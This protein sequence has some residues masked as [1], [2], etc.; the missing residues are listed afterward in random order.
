VVDRLAEEA[1]QAAG[2]CS[3]EIHP[4][5]EGV[6]LLVEAGRK[7]ELIEAL[8]AGGSDVIRVNP[9]K[10]TLEEVFLSLVGGAR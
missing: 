4:S 2:N 3:A 1:A 8:W 6:R 9:I 5:P 7:R 10:D